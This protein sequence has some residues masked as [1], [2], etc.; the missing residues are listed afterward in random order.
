MQ[1]QVFLINSLIQI[2]QELHKRGIFIGNNMSDNV[3]VEG[4]RVII[5][6]S[7]CGSKEEDNSKLVLLVR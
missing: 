2:I 7:E 1:N 4:L 5:E 3:F 6:P